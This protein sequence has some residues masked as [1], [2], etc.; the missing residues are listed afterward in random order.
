MKIGRNALCPC[1]SGKKYKKCC[2]LGNTPTDPIV[3]S[4]FARIAGKVDSVRN[5]VEQFVFSD[6]IKVAFCL[7]S[8][9]G[10]RSALAQAFTLNIAIHTH[11]HSGTKRIE[12]YEEL[13]AFFDLLSPYTSITPA[14]D[15]I[16]D[17]Y[18]EVFVTVHGNR[19]PIITGTGYLQ[20]YSLLRFVVTLMEMTGHEEELVT[21]LDYYRF[22]IDATIEY[23][24]PNQQ[25]KVKYEL[26]TEAYWNCTKTLFSMP[27]FDCR[28]KQIAEIVA[29]YQ[30]N[31]E[32]LHFTKDNNNIFPLFNTSLILDFYKG[33]LKQISQDEQTKYVENT[34]LSILEN[35]YNFASNEPPRAILHPRIL[36]SQTN[37]IVPTTPMLFSAKDNGKMLIGIQQNSQL[38]NDSVCKTIDT[39]KTLHRENHLSIVEGYVRDDQKGTFGTTVPSTVPIIFAIINCPQDITAPSFSLEEVDQEFVCS[40]ADMLYLLGFSDGFSEIIDFIEYHKKEQAQIFTYGGKSNLFFAWKEANR[41]IIPGAIECNFMNIDFNQTDEYVRDHFRDYLQHLPARGIFDEPLAWRMQSATAG[42][43]EVQHRGC[44]GFGGIIKKLPFDTH[45]FFAHNVSFYTIEDFHNQAELTQKVVDELNEQLFI[46]HGDQ[47][48]EIPVLKGKVLQ[49]LYMPW[50]YAKTHY[51]YR[52]MN[53]STKTFV[54]CDGFV[55][56]DAVHIRYAVSSDLLKAIQTTQNRSIENTYLLELLQPLRK[57]SPYRFEELQEKLRLEED[58]PHTVGVFAV[59]QTYYYSPLSTSTVVPPYFFVEVRKE[60][61]KQ[62][63][64]AGVLPKEYHGQD[65]TEIIRKL[66]QMV[67]PTFETLIQQIDQE[68]LHNM[69]LSYYADQQHGV[70]IHMKRYHSFT[71]LAPE[72]QADFEARTRAERQTCRRNVATAQYLIETNLAVC[73]ESTVRDCSEADIQ[74]LLAFADWLVVLQ[75]AA[76]LCHSTDKDM[77]I[78]IDDM[79]CVDTIVSKEDQASL[80]AWVERKYN[81]EDYH[82]HGDDVDVGYAEKTCIAFHEDTGIDLK[83]LLDFLSYMQLGL[84]EDTQVSEQ[85]PNVF[86]IDR[87]AVAESYIKRFSD[88]PP[89]VQD[90]DAIID[91]IT[92]NEL[93]IKTVNGKTYGLLPIWERK[94]RDN[95]IEVKP[96]IIRN[97]NCVFSPVLLHTLELMWRN[98]IMDW[99]L[100]YEVGLSKTKSSLTTWKKYYED[101]MVHDIVQCF[102]NAGFTWA[103]PDVELIKRFPKE[104][105]PLELGDYDIMAYCACRHELWIIESKV[106]QKVAS[107]YEDQN[108]QKT[109]F[110]SHG[111]DQKFQRRIDYAHANLAK[112]LAS[113]H[114]E[115][116]DCKLISYMVTNKLFGSRYKEIQFEIIAY[117]ELK[118]ILE[119]N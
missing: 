80:A 21:L 93:S 30:S 112:I 24:S 48:A 17:D 19:Y 106:L 117:S 99:F 109:F 92:L 72:V 43:F 95:R 90:V 73:H 91:F 40:A 118:K 54:F 38:I 23:N 116:P 74:Y 41:Q 45:V 78:C 31:L 94:K 47:I 110:F 15:F 62:C 56:K 98:G 97:G 103:Y 7:N 88:N 46:R 63:R 10:N 82:I 26:P 76:D 13:S 28:V 87:H 104:G 27:E 66:Q 84:I 101:K 61:A 83:L 60:I 22:L 67:I 57:Y 64:A 4:N 50:E 39:I 108:Q 65:A 75:E 86:S 81:T 105:Y 100:P 29:P 16:I 59:Q 11:R 69:A 70:I 20:G 37:K 96:I 102:K 71:N 85:L 5:I 77:H 49:L 12:T 8:W 34:L 9:R 14:E 25:H 35:A 36:D 111:D 33:V 114:I 79:Y 52:F 89:D 3:S 1:G 42:Y 68:Q 2:M 115:D 53:D 18:G 58:A 107:I 55:E 113:F 6:I 32:Q 119:H 44:K 51:A